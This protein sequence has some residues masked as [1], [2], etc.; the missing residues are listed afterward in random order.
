MSILSL[1][2][3]FGCFGTG[4]L[5]GQTLGSLPLGLT[6]PVVVRQQGLGQDGFAPLGHLLCH[7][8]H[9]SGAAIA[10]G[11]GHAEHA[12]DAAVFIIAQSR[13]ITNKKQGLFAIFYKFCKISHS[14]EMC[15][16]DRA[17][18]PPTT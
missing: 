2:S 16:R 8:G 10:E 12:R 11:R 15:I 5:C 18:A 14:P 7:I 4:G 13:A 1:C 17:C 6:Q 9:R 3:I